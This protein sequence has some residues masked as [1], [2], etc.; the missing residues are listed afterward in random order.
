MNICPEKAI[1]YW[2]TNYRLYKELALAYFSDEKKFIHLHVTDDIQWQ[3]KLVTFFQGN[4]VHFDKTDGSKSFNKS[5]RNIVTNPL[6]D[7]YMSYY[8]KTWESGT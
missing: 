5:P 1:D 4:D 8:N 2:V 6:V 7:K 3:E